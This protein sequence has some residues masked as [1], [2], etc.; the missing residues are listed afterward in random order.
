MW[1]GLYGLIAASGLR[2]YAAPKGPRRRA[3]L[4]LWAAQLALNGLWPRLFFGRRRPRAALVDS[5]LLLATS[6]AYAGIARRV[7]PTASKLFAPY[8]GW[9][10]FATLLNA[11]IVRRNPEV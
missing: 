7:D 1:T 5:A 9:L 8:L 3:A 11:E 10:A 6:A 2:T 4:G